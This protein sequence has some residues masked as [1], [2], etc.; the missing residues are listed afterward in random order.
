[1]PRHRRTDRTR[2]GKRRATGRP[3]AA[4]WGRRRPVA[5]I[6]ARW[7][8]RP[9]VPACPR[10]SPGVAPRGQ[11]PEHGAG[12]HA[13]RRT[14]R[15]GQEGVE[16]RARQVQRRDA[17]D[18]LGCRM[19]LE[20]KEVQ[21]VESAE[22]LTTDAVAVHI[23]RKAVHQESASN[24]RRRGP[25]IPDPTGPS[26]LVDL[27]GVVAVHS[28]DRDQIGQAPCLA[29]PLRHARPSQGR[30]PPSQHL[31]WRRRTVSR[32]SLAIRARRHLVEILATDEGRANADQGQGR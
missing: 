25:R 17:V 18:A 15:R 26:V 16:P 10:S 32:P 30:I 22:V 4:P 13:A 14:G 7:V 3:I 9:P 5:A 24:V 20:A 29:I 11:P 8:T 21:L 1:M 6:A 28:Q 12:G 31:Q 19:L 27:S 23:D 2:V